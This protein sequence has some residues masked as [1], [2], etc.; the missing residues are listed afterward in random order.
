MGY[1]RPALPNHQ[2]TCPTSPIACDTSRYAPILSGSTTTNPN[3]FSPIPRP[4]LLV[5]HHHRRRLCDISPA[6]LLAAWPSLPLPIRPPDSPSVVP[7]YGLWSGRQGLRQRSLPNHASSSS[8]PP[9]PN[10]PL[11]VAECAGG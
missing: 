4:K 5:P 3:S 1:H 11:L 2:P 6:T 8:H 7:S 10:P 9:M